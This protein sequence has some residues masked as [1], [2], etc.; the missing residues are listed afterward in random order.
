M[1]RSVL[2]FHQSLIFHD[3]EKDY[4]TNGI[5]QQLFAQVIPGKSRGS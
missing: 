5:A 3:V 2:E 1:T 4:R